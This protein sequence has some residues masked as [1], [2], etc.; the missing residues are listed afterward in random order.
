MKI[1]LNILK[2]FIKLDE[3]L[4]KNISLLEDVGLEVKKLDKTEN[5]VL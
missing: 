2:S 4:N 1:S 3:D 5:D